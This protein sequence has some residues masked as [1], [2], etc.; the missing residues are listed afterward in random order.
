ML[1]MA[2]ADQTGTEN[3]ELNGELHDDPLHFSTDCQHNHKIFEIKTRNFAAVDAIYGTLNVVC[4]ISEKRQVPRCD[5]R[6]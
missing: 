1:D 3:G 2:F 6:G 5:G 4:M